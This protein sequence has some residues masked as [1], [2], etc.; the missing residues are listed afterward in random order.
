MDT[1]P[2]TRF[3]VQYERDDH[4]WQK[5]GGVFASVEAAEQAIRSPRY[6]QSLRYRIV[7]YVKGARTEDQ[8]AVR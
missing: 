5:T 3:Q 7:V 8:A 1:S 4:S 2:V 6:N